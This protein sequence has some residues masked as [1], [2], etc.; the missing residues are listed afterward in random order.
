M[1][2]QSHSQV[3]NVDNVPST[4]LSHAQRFQ[5][6]RKQLGMAAGARKLGCTL[7]ELPSGKRSWPVELS[8]LSVVKTRINRR[9]FVGRSS[10]RRYST[11]PVHTYSVEDRMKPLGRLDGYQ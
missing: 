8:V 11:N 10:R 7:V 5:L 3:V 6:T 4:E 9:S 1:D 2:K